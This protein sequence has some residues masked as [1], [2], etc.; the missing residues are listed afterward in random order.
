MSHNASDNKNDTPE[1]TPLD[2]TF[3]I[4]IECLLLRVSD[5]DDE[6][7]ISPLAG[8]EAIHTALSQPMTALCSSCQQEHS[9]ALPLNSVVTA[10]W[11]QASLDREYTQ[12]TIDEDNSVALT[13][14]EL[15][16]IQDKPRF[17]EL[18]RIE[19]KSRI[20][21][22]DKPL[23]TTLSSDLNHVHSISWQDEIRTVYNRLNEVFNTAP[24]KPGFR[25][26][27]NTNCG[28]HVHVGNEHKGFPLSTVKNILSMYVANEM[29][30]DSI[31]STDRITGSTLAFTTKRTPN[32]NQYHTEDVLEGEI[33]NLPWSAHFLYMAFKFTAAEEMPKIY[34]SM[35]ND[36]P[37]NAFDEYPSLKAISKRIDVPSWLKLIRCAS[38]IKKLRNMQG[39]MAHNSVV[40]LENLA[41]FS[42]DGS[43]RGPSGDKKM[44][45]EFRQHAGTLSS[46][47]AI[48]W[49]SVLLSLTRFSQ[50]QSLAQVKSACEETWSNSSHS[51]LD[52]LKAVNVPRDT[53][54]HY[55]TVLGLRPHQTESYADSFRS[56]QLQ[57]ASRFGS[58]DFYLDVATIFID[59]R[60]SALSI[61]RVKDRIKKKLVNGCY[62][63]F[64]ARYVEKLDVSSVEKTQLTVG[65]KPDRSGEHEPPS[66]PAVRHYRITNP[67]PP[68]NDEE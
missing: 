65:W 48:A 1:N 56:R 33:Y 26:F 11:K 63:Q 55:E 58:D 57:A 50:N 45:I 30:I 27:V 35:C 16:P 21:F 68:S 41:D 44:T 52:F 4:E 36:Y 14:P 46:T 19:I 38:N 67:D 62:G 18:D 61:Q 37:I 40:N 13:D 23:T 66:A 34:N 12:W 5:P 43:N 10:G 32:L 2:L 28:L 31:H 59:E 25:L 7:S 9:F 8:R 3:G 64:D 6:S 51:A 24:G 47:E 39:I 17:V 54:E 60:T 20:I 53:Y 29:A 15:E 42:P 22:A 49:I